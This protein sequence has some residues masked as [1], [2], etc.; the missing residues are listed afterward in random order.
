MTKMTGAK[1]MSRPMGLFVWGDLA[2]SGLAASLAQALNLE[3]AQQGDYATLA[4]ALALGAPI[5]VIWADPAVS[6]TAA[7][8][9]GGSPSD[10]LA[11]WT[12]K[13]QVLLGLHRRHRRQLLLLSEA[14]LASDDPLTVAQLRDRLGVEKVFLPV[15][16]A[17]D[18][19][20]A[21]AKMLASLAVRE[22]DSLRMPLAELEAGSIYVPRPALAPERLDEVGQWLLGDRQRHDLL[23]EQARLDQTALEKALAACDREAV[24][25]IAAER[26]AAESRALADGATAASDAL[27]A[28]LKQSEETLAALTQAKLQNDQERTL[29][30]DQ[31]RLMS[32]ALADAEEGLTELK[33]LRIAATQESPKNSRAYVEVQTANDARARAETELA[34]ALTEFHRLRLDTEQL[35]ET[36]EHLDLMSHDLAR[37]HETLIDRENDLAGLRALHSKV[38]IA[39]FWKFAA[40]I[41]R[42]SRLIGRHRT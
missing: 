10:A 41:R 11:E 38:S 14:A 40:P 27:R 15:T 8:A 7:L 6:L 4:T 12:S 30:H 5:A 37:I 3:V 16:E 34:N 19:W 13:A 35:A 21:F 33:T 9:D 23:A 29:L 36:R 25:R 20:N 32:Q 22:L 24:D 2:D 26:A 18:S 28:K 39:N 42:V 31:I 17:R 1:T